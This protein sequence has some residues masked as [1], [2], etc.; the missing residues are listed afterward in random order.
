M[1]YKFPVTLY[2]QQCHE[3][4][5]TLY[6]QQCHEFPITLYAQQCHMSFARHVQIQT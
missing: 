6:A 4:P 3:F 1:S 5:V 2:A